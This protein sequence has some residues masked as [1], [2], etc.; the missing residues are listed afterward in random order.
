MRKGLLLIVVAVVPLLIFVGLR[1]NSAPFFSVKECQCVQNDLL[2]D[3]YFFL[4]NTALAALIADKIA[5]HEVIGRLKQQF[6][7]LKKVVISYQPSVT[8]VVVSAHEPVCSINNSVILTDTHELFSKNMFTSE[9]I[10]DIP[11]LA[12]EQE[13]MT[14]ISSFVFLLQGLPQGVHEAYKLELIN[15]HC[16]HF[17]DKEQPN[18]IIMSSVAQEKSLQLLAHCES[19]KQTINARKGFDKGVKWIADTRFAHYIIAYKA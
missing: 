9:V 12:V 7:V 19:V 18:F 10:A 6:P 3:D 17:I 15:E 14:N 4:I 13:S 2:S 16:V 11:Q 8:K 5:A 1:R